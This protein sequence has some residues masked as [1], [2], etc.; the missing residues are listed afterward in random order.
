VDTIRS[1]VPAHG[2][3]LRHDADALERDI[4]AF[5]HQ[6]LSAREGCLVLTRASRW[7]RV[8]ERLEALGSDVTGALETGRLLHFDSDPLIAALFAGETFDP[9]VLERKVHPALLWLREA[10]GG[11]PVRAY[12]DLVDVLW[13]EGRPAHAL[14]LEKAWH[15]LLKRDPVTLLCGYVVDPLAAALDSRAFLPLC[16]AHG[17]VEPCHHPARRDAIR[18][19]IDEVL[20]AY[21][22]G[23]LQSLLAAT[24]IPTGGGGSDELTLMWLRTEVPHLAQRVINRARG[25]LAAEALEPVA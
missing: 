1:P 7:A 15:D 5:L 16:R 25:K 24:G 11:A 4:A 14:L 19:A 6:C 3:L 12:G 8:R 20:G 21:E 2:L 18:G 10:T 13:Q 22:L 23:R 9:E 17:H